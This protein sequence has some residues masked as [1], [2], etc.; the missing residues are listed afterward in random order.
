MN[1][2]DDFRLLVEGVQKK[3]GRMDAIERDKATQLIAAILHHSDESVTDLLPLFEELQSEAV[4]DGVGIVWPNLSSE[5][6]LQIR[7]WL[8]PPRTE[9]AQR[10]IALLAARLAE[11]DGSTA[12]D[13][14]DQL[15]PEHRLN[16][17]LKQLLITSLFS[18]GRTIRFENLCDA[19][20]AKSS[21]RVLKTLSALAFDATSAIEPMSRYRLAVATLKLLVGHKL[22]QTGL[23]V[24]L[25]SRIVVEVE[26][27]P[28]G[29]REQFDSW[30]KNEAP[31]LWQEFFPLKQ[32]A[33][34]APA[35]AKPNQAK[36]E[37]VQ[38]TSTLTF[39][40]YLDQRAQTLA[41]ESQVLAGIRA[42]VTNSRAENERQVATWRAKESE[43]NKRLQELTS[44]RAT[45]ERN[46]AD[47]NRRIAESEG[48]VMR[49]EHDRN[50]QHERLTQQIAANA[51]GRVDEFKNQVAL[52]LSRQMIDLPNRD[53]EV[54]AELGRVLL[55]Q[56]HQ[57]I[58]VLE[59]LG[60]NL[61]A[62]RS[63]R[64]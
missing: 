53:A 42:L 29:L 18:N 13:L 25:I 6:R 47:A 36:N 59:E 21:L 39:D 12:V 61:D 63:V 20:S 54:S 15:I 56:F 50:A 35:S 30:L 48:A 32:N 31:Q 37:E 46:L 28:Q 40:H 4:A 2:V 8:P 24:D 51:N 34:S 3:K 64:Q 45:L 16:K 5:R 17:E 58:Q 26:R 62:T 49:A 33:A 7:R 55:L 44:A 52:T 14:L 38:E 41:A 22:Y 19:S 27:W 60:I 57:L 11:T 10:R 23:S 1:E 43:L 9:R